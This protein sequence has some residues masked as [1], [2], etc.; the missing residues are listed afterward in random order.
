MTD[1]SKN[2]FDFSNLMTNFDPA[3][4]VEQF[5]NALTQYQIPGVD[6]R[7]LLDSQRKNIEALSAANKHAVEGMRAVMARQQEMLSETMAEAQKVMKDI[8]A[9]SSPSDAAAKQAEIAK[10]AFNK[11]LSNMCELAEMTA[12]SNTAAYDAI[13][14][15]LAEGIQEIKK[16][17]ESFGR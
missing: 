6:T 12:R 14:K 10:E 8:G 2:P 4:L 15:R 13:N 11:A 3:R 7:A 17:A 1:S 9:S 5:N 16:L